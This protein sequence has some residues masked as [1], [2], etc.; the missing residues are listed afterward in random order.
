MNT[1]QI[2]TLHLHDF[3]KGRNLRPVLNKLNRTLDELVSIIIEPEHYH[4]NMVYNSMP[5]YLF[6]FND[7]VWMPGEM[8]RSK[9]QRDKAKKQLYC[10]KLYCEE[11]FDYSPKIGLF[12]LYNNTNIY[13]N[14]FYEI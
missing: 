4:G 3:I 6:R 7:G 1:E 9:G 8:K 14:H 5:D 10:G 13:E 12:V 11:M 2:H